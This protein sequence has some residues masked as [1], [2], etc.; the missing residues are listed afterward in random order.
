MTY[1]DSGSSG[2]SG[3]NFGVAVVCE[4]ES[5]DQAQALVGQS[6]EERLKLFRDH[7][8]EFRGWLS[9]DDLIEFLFAEY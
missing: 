7:G 1:V 3:G 9:A 8:C 6:F 4:P 2:V 5:G